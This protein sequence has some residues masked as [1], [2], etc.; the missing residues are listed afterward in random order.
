M[1][2]IL[3]SF[4][5][6]SLFF[7]SLNFALFAQVRTAVFFEQDTLEWNNFSIN[8]KQGIKLVYN[9][10]VILPADYSQITS[11]SNHEYL[12]VRRNDSLG[13]FL[14]KK[15][16]M[17]LPVSYKNIELSQKIYLN[18]QNGF[19][20]IVEAETFDSKVD[21][22]VIQNDSIYKV[23]SGMKDVMVTPANELFILSSDSK[24]GL[25]SVKNDSLLLSFDYDEI[26]RFAYSPKELEGNNLH[27]KVKKNDKMGL[28]QINKSFYLPIKF[29]SIS[30][31]NECV[32]GWDKNGATLF[33]SQKKVWN[34]VNDVINV[35]ASTSILALQHANLKWSLWSSDQHKLIDGKL[36]DSVQ[37]F[38]S[39][40]ERAEKIPLMAY[41]KNAIYLVR[42]DSS[43][44]YL[45]LDNASIDGIIAMDNF[46]ISSNGK[47][48]VYSFLLE[49]KVASKYDE[50]KS[51]YGPK[52][53]KDYWACK[54]GKY[55]VFIDNT[56]SVYDS[57][58]AESI[59]PFDLNTYCATNKGKIAIINRSENVNTGF[60]FDF[61]NTSI[62]KDK[63]A[64]IGT[65]YYYV[66]ANGTKNK[67]DRIQYSKIGYTSLKDVSNAFTKIMNSD[68]DTLLYEFALNM[69]PDYHS[70]EFMNN[71][72]KDY[73]DVFS[74]FS[75][76]ERI[77][78]AKKYYQQLLFIKKSIYRDANDKK[79]AGLGFKS[80]KLIDFH[81]DR[82]K[83]MKGTESPILITIDN[84]TIQIKLGEL[85]IIDGYVKSFTMPKVIN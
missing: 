73:R 71:N 12:T 64:R 5:L 54:K 14:P 16:L 31:K 9:K 21:F 20:F 23:F 17:I 19:R 83:L 44:L 43:N 13:L 6:F 74:S 7:S 57:I 4:I 69:T 30:C 60:I 62:A 63:L 84:K 42:K 11:I 32:I 18:N 51:W 41:D 58:K 39:F 52:Y 27:F 34:I 3:Q 50:I 46:L 22:F 66:V 26:S 68:E 40:D 61:V 35:K 77:A 55:W 80:D 59:K 48:G 49:N 75:E 53:T 29:D 36:V 33:P 38:E 70:M 72:N 45:K 67:I 1:K 79:V 47:K 65:D 85:M 2:F 8:G 24:S 56:K 28:Y 82:N 76:F 25:Y 78:A 15:Q 37:M 10:K 81:I